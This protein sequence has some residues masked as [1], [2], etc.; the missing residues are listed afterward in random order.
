MTIEHSDKAYQII[1]C[2]FP[3]IELAQK[4][5]TDLI[6]KKLAACVSLSPVQS[7]YEWE[8]DVKH[9]QEHLLMIK[10]R[11]ERYDE[12]ENLL[13]SLHPFVVPEIVAI[14]IVNGFSYYLNW[15]DKCCDRS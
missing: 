5:A 2:T 14:P 10:T 11:V 1:L 9:E 4:C 15:I 12:I 3:S 13:R 8:S 7:F 6:K